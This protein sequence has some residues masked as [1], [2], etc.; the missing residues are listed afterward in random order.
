MYMNRALKV[1]L[2]LLFCLAV[3]ESV[4]VVQVFIH[5][6]DNKCPWL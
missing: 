2:Y 3:P 5:Q 6:L 1:P 4:R